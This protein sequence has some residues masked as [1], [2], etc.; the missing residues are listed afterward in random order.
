MVGKAVVSNGEKSV[1][2]STR[3]RGGEGGKSAFDIH[4]YFHVQCRPALQRLMIV[5]EIEIKI[6]F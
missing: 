4:V 1:D 3:R 6:H 2:D 5:I